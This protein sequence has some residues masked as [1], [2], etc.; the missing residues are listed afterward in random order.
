MAR[1]CV[2]SLVKIIGAH[3]NVKDLHDCTPVTLGWA[4]PDFE[5]VDCVRLTPGLLCVVIDT[6]RKKEKIVKV[7]IP[8][9][10]TLYTASN[11]VTLV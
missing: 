11:E 1:L 4:G 7:M 3:K 8:D 10:R 2:G 6:T 9:G 5:A